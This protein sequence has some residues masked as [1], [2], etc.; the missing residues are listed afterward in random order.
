MAEVARLIFEEV[1][2]PDP[3]GQVYLLKRQIL[4]QMEAYLKF[5]VAPLIERAQCAILFLE[6]RLE[7]VV[8]PFRYKGVVDRI[9]RR[10]NTTYIIDYKTGASADRL[11]IDFGKLNVDDRESWSRA[12][13][14]LQLPFYLLLCEQTTGESM[15]DLRAAFMLLGKVRLDEGAELPS[16]ANTMTCTT[17]APG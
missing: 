11:S 13:G 4:R 17:A 12:I 1:Y 15:E 10:D 6:H 3:L 16:S 14:S 9:E 7:T 5:F 2:G 8:A